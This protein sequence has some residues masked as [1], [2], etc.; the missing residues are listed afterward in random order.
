MEQKSGYTVEY[1]EQ[2]IEKEVAIL[3]SD[4]SLLFRDYVARSAKR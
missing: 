2:V 4:L 1:S 3:N